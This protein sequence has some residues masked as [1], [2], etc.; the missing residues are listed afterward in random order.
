MIPANYCTITFIPRL[1]SQRV[2]SLKMRKFINFYWP[3]HAMCLCRLVLVWTCCVCLRVLSLQHSERKLTFYEMKKEHQFAETKCGHFLWELLPLNTV[4]SMVPGITV[5]CCWSVH[6]KMCDPRWWIII[7]FVIKS[8][9]QFL[10]Y[11][12]CQNKDILIS[13]C[14]SIAI[15]SM[16]CSILALA[17]SQ[18]TSVPKYSPVEL[19]A[20]L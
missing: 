4:C 16:H 15:G 13:L 19:S 20:W 17:F 18:S 1:P 9:I 6:I 10:H 2:G 14:C 8:K 7:I 12:Q 11:L 3:L 5:L